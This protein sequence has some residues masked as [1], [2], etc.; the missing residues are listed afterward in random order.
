MIGQ[1]KTSMIA[2]LVRDA[3]T[4]NPIP[5]AYVGVA[6]PMTAGAHQITKGDGKAVFTLPVAAGS[7]VNISVGADG[8]EDVEKVAPSR[9]KADSFLTVDL[10]QKTTII[11][12]KEISPWYVV[13]ATLLVLGPLVYNWMRD[14]K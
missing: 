2:V 7:P 11:P 14:R 1:A 4:G 9:P 8:Y 5:G 3:V 13:G 6:G 10:P 12:E